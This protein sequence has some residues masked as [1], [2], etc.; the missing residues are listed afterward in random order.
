MSSRALTTLLLLAAALQLPFA[1]DAGAGTRTITLRNGDKVTGEVVSE[2]NSTIVVSHPV[3]G[4]LTI[5]RQ[6]V[7]PTVTETKPN[8]VQNKLPGLM[9]TRLLEGWKRHLAAG[10]KG[11]EGNTVTWDF[12]VSLD[13]SKEDMEERQ[14]L[15]AAYYYETTDRKV[16]KEKGHANY[17]HDWLMPDSRW[18][19]YSYGRYE[20][21]S[22]K[23]WRHRLS[24]S[25]GPGYDLYRSERFVLRSRFGLGFD[26]TWG[27]DDEFTPEAIAGAEFSWKPNGAHRISS[28]F[29]T[30][31]NLDSQ[32]GYRTWLQAKWSMQLDFMLG[33]GVELGLEHEYE[34]I[35]DER[36]NDESHYDLLYFWR[37]GLDF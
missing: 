4:L 16:D 37:I 32:G 36:S 21:D 25:A 30:Y 13:L 27:D 7:A 1:P 9:G 2:T 33:L 24:L 5:P 31:K 34:S 20:F 19:Y 14:S 15:A 22:L 10:V 11:E 35:I 12:N 26:K 6:E 17:V 18:F 29:L 8:Q 23:W 28:E 3:L